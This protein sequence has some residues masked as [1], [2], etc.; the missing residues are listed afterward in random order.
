MSPDRLRV[1]LTTE[2]YNHFREVPGRGL[3]GLK[4]M[5]FTAGLFVGLDEAG[6]AYRYCYGSY[7]EAFAALVEW[8]GAGHPSGPWIKLK[9]QGEDIL[10]P[11]ATSEL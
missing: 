7:A 9:G 2:G 11:G 8:D 5:L 3:C 6:Y 10:G 1:L 4:P